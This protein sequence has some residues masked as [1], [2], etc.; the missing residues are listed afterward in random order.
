MT[1]EYWS[2]RGGPFEGQ[3]L[4]LD[5]ED[6]H[7]CT[8]AT[9]RASPT[10]TAHAPSRTRSPPRSGSQISTTSA[11]TL[12][13]QPTSSST[14]TDRASSS[15]AAAVRVTRKEQGRITTRLAPGRHPA[16]IPLVM[17]PPRSAGVRRHLGSGVQGSAAEPEYPPPSDGQ[18]GRPTRPGR[19]SGSRP[20]Q[21]G[22]SRLPCGA[23][24]GDSGSRGQVAHQW[25]HSSRE[26]APADAE[27]ASDLR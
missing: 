14:V 24:A 7:D 21:A 6:G 16:A 1:K 19:P 27:T 4:Y 12:R 8:S 18:S 25:A 23:G 3:V 17:R 20:A 2:V 5:L 9:R 13:P 10:C 11:S 15:A 26:A 22:R